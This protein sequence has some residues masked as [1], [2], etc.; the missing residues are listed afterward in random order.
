M[1][2][3]IYLLGQEVVELGGDTLAKRVR[4]FVVHSLV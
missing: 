2:M 4:I 3:A 1:Q